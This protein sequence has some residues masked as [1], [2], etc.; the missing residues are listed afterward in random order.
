MRSMQEKR[1]E[2]E[3]QSI[4]KIDSNILTKIIKIEKDEYH[5][6]LTIPPSLLLSTDVTTGIEFLLYIQCNF[7][8]NPP[9]LFC[10]TPFAFPSICDGRDMLEAVLNNQW[11]HQTKLIDIVNAIPN[12][13]IHYINALKSKEISLVG[14]YYLDN[15][16]DMALM[17]SL[18]V[19]FEKVKEKIQ[20]SGKETE[21]TRYVMISDIFFLL[22]END[23]IMDIWNR[24][25]VRLAFWSNLRALKTIK[26]IVNGD[27]CE[28]IWRTK[29]DNSYNM[30]LKTEKTQQIVDLI[31][32]NLKQFGIDY[33]VTK[34]ILGPKTGIIPAI[35]IEMVEKQVIE[36]EEKIISDKSS[37]QLL[38][39]MTLYEK[40]IEYYS[41]TNNPRY[42]L[43]T[44]KIQ[45]IMAQPEY[46]QL[47]EVKEEGKEKRD[48]GNDKKNKLTEHYSDNSEKEGISNDSKEAKKEGIQKINEEKEE[49]ALIR[50]S[51]TPMP[52]KHN[53]F[54]TESFLNNNNTLQLS[55]SNNKS[56]S[57]SKQPEQ[58]S[59]PTVKVS[60]KK[61]DLNLDFNDDEEES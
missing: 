45:E 3:L 57:K 34:S 42:Q 23:N 38:F 58:I 17:E 9:R 32:K 10:L 46:N 30:K 61:E 15:K 2:Q 25:T 27:S 35:D 39:L 18:P 51:K 24:N 43:F 22:F 41:A 31:M 50:K 55:I 6:T 1:L 52:I 4:E 40:A 36:I 49:S 47:L 13:I 21:I 19:Y 16:Y 26:K 44:K 56:E 12:F 48:G 37:E 60:V 28:L 8:F 20:M 11:T 14:N 7:P 54:E 29:N 59:T 33:T 5:I 53:Q